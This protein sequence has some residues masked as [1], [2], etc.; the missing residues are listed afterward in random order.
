MTNAE[1]S[2]K[3][4]AKASLKAKR[5]RQKAFRDRRRQRYEAAVAALAVF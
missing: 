1:A 2:L 5:K 4:V 3:R